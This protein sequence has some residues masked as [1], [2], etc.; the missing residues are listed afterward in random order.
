MACCSSCPGFLLAWGLLRR[1]DRRE[2]G[3]RL[4]RLGAGFALAALPQLIVW[5]VQYGV[6]FVVPHARLHGAGFF[7]SAPELWGTL[8]SPRGGVFVAYP[9]LLVAFVGVLLLVPRPV[10]GEGAPEGGGALFDARYVAGLLPVLLLAWWVNASIF[11]WY[12]VRRYTGLV[13]FLAPGLL[14]LLGSLARAGT[15]WLALLAFLAWRYDDAVDARRNNPGDPVPVR[16]ALR[17]LDDRLA[18]EAYGLLEPVAPRTA[19][20][21]LAS[22]TGEALLEG[23]VSY[24]DLASAPALLELPRRAVFVGGPEL[25]DG[26]VARWVTGRYA[27]LTVPLDWRG[28]LLVRVEARALET[29]EPQR[30]ALEWN[31]ALCGERPMEPAWREYSFEVPASAVRHG[32]NMLVLRFA[33]GPLYF[34]VRGSGPREVRPAALSWLTLNRAGPGVP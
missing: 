17:T 4:V 14:L 18:A 30:M 25:E 10:R 22:Y 33:R 19:V 8:F 11:D 32:T 23:D 3:L 34:R 16:L 28:P 27:R 9:A 31:G 2:A 5:Q 1:G 21:L 26:R 15:P 24:L 7:R 29:L 6:P 12:Q 20:R 13:P